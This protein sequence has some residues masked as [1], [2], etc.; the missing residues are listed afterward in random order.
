MVVMWQVAVA[1]CSA[2]VEDTNRGNYSQQEIRVFYN[3]SMW[4]QGKK[5]PRGIYYAVGMSKVHL[6]LLL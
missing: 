2:M 5:S 3:L 6:T 4:L 1:L